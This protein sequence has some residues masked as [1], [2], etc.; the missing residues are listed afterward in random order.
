MLNEINISD[1]DIFYFKKNGYFKIKNFVKKEYIENILFEIK[2]IFNIQFKN[3]NIKN[4]S[5][6]ENLITL[7]NSDFNTF[8]NCAKNC[9]NLF[10]IHNFGSSI[11]IYNLLKKFGIKKP[12]ICTRPVTFINY[13]K[14]SKQK[15]NHTIFEHQ[16]WR[17]MQGSI[18]SV[19]LWVPLVNINKDLGALEVS[20]GSHLRGLIS[21]RVENS[22]GRT[23]D[24]ISKKLK[25]ESIEVD[26]GD[27]LIFSSFLVH[28]SGNNI[29]DNIRF[30]SHFRYNDMLEESYIDRG[31]PTPYKYGPDDK[32]LFPNLKTKKLIK[33][34]MK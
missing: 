11:E 16:D 6:E 30:S 34:I 13:E 12:N 18:N 4:N 28:R 33:N 7:F 31:F 32:L 23:P 25:F 24:E 17:S 22:F 8:L 27:C 3:K 15:I 10:L 21:D 14:T 5:F 19:V 2:N 20:P 9:Q 1:D 29:T 26:L